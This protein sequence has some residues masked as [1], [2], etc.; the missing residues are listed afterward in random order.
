MNSVPHLYKY[1]EWQSS[2]AIKYTLRILGKVLLGSEY[3][4]R[5]I[6][7]LNIMEVIEK[8]MN[9]INKEIR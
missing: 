2:K 9:R 7:S 4:W 8:L 6:L 1:L 3:E 5:F